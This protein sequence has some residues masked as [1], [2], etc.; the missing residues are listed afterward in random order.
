MLTSSQDKKG[1]EDWK[2]MK[3]LY[4]IIAEE[5]DV[6]HK[7]GTY[8]FMVSFFCLFFLFYALSW[9]IGFMWTYI[10]MLTVHS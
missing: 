10:H 4:L 7:R 3:L 6:H 2:L 1:D 5:T 8:T 9:W